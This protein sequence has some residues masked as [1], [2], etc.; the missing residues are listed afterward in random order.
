[1]ACF[2]LHFL[3][4]STT[5]IKREDNTKMLYNKR[6]NPRVSYRA[7]ARLIQSK[8]SGIRATVED[9]SIHGLRVRHETPLTEPN[10]HLIMQVADTVVQAQCRIARVEDQHNGEIETGLQFIRFL[11]IGAVQQI[12]AVLS[13]SDGVSLVS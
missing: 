12:Q 8:G 10:C 2:L 7:P 5:I 9:I 13:G 3:E 6:A 1:M 4:K 11:S